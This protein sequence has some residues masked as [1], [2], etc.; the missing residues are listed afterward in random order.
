MAGGEES[1]SS[2][3][4]SPRGGREADPFLQRLELEDT[5]LLL[6]D[7]RFNYKR[8]ARQNNSNVAQRSGLTLGAGIGSS[9]DHHVAMAQQ[10]RRSCTP[11]RRW[12]TAAH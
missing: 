4:S 9:V 2:A 1:P 3:S 10:V 11:C 8:A 7:K 5:M 12:A 6:Q